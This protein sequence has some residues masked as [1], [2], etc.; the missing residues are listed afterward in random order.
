MKTDDFCITGN[1]IYTIPADDNTSLVEID[2]L[3]NVDRSPPPP[4]YYAAAQQI[5]TETNLVQGRP[6]Y[7]GY[8]SQPAP[9]IIEYSHQQQTA[10]AMQATAPPESLPP[11]Q[12]NTESLPSFNTA[13]QKEAERQEMALQMPYMY[14]NI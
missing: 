8:T 6:V 9:P 3:P 10:A 11:Y 2:D 5:R 14:G 1:C 4:D 12:E 13:V 7:H